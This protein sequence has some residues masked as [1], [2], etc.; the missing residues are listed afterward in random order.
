MTFSKHLRT[1]IC[2]H[3]VHIMTKTTRVSEKLTAFGK[4]V[5]LLKMFWASFLDHHMVDVQ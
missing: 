3:F 1:Y 4:C 5:M 2:P